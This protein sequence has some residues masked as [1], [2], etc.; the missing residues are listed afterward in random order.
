MR[1]VRG[2]QPR[3]LK[4]TARAIHCGVRWQ[5]TATVSAVRG[6]V[7]WQLTATV[8]AVRGGVRWQLTATVSAVRGGA[9]WRRVHGTSLPHDGD[10]LIG[11]DLDALDDV[12][13]VELDLRDEGAPITRRVV[14]FAD[15]RPAVRGDH[16]RQSEQKPTGPSQ[17]AAPAAP[18]AE[19]DGAITASSRSSRSSRRSSAAAAAAAAAATFANNCGGFERCRRA[20]STAL[21]APCERCARR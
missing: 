14:H 1:P 13:R 5:L 10:A 16:P 3:R 21:T 8:S 2:N 20:V 4:A 18:A 17:P 19:A 7:R 15:R 11:V 6:G 12:L 9:R